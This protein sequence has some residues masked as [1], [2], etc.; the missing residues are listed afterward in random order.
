MVVDAQGR[1][2]A[3]SDDPDRPGRSFA[4]RPEV[5]DAL[6]GRKNDG[7]RFSNTLGQR[8]AFVAV[9]VNPGGRVVGAVRVTYPAR[10]LDAR[11]RRNWLV[12]GLVGVMVLGGVSL[13]SL[14]LARSVAA[15]IRAIEEAATRLGEGDLSARAP[16]PASPPEL[17][18]L[19]QEVND[20][21]AKLGR[22]VANQQDF[23]ADASHQLRT[24]LAA[25]R[26][27]LEMLEGQVTSDEASEDMVAALSEVHR[28]SR[29]IDGLLVLARAEQ[30]SVRPEATSLGA[31][32]RERWAAWA[33]VAD[34]RGVKLAVKVPTGLS[35]VVTPGNL[36]QVLDN[37]VA[38][39]LEVSP[40]DGR[41]WLTGAHE[42]GWAVLHVTDKAR[43]WT[44]SGG[45]RPS[46]ASGGRPSPN[47]GRRGAASAWAWP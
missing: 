7:I 37:L 27:R 44:P 1:A 9:P 36:A 12:L 17:R 8:L 25:L 24:S 45:L 10:V 39:A 41:I 15:P 14:V 31:V 21:G 47:A 22:L 5:A 4:S 33:P 6:A 40:R 23:V 20:A 32:V 43:A 3:D 2:V 42:D 18:V 16:V 34:E 46:T 13:V 35:A 28:L 19:A 29:L 26:L 30:A 11:I 38:N